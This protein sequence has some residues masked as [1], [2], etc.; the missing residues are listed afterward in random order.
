MTAEMIPLVQNSW[1][2]RVPSPWSSNVACSM[3]R[4]SQLPKR[5]LRSFSRSTCTISLGLRIRPNLAVY[6]VPAAL[7]GPVTSVIRVSPSIHSCARSR[8]V[9][10]SKTCSPWRPHLD[11]EAMVTHARSLVRSVSRAGR[12]NNDSEARAASHHGSQHVELGSWRGRVE[13]VLDQPAGR[14]ET[15]P[16]PPRADHVEVDVGAVSGD[17]VTKV[18]L[19]SERQDGKVV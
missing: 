9:H 10:R 13:A 5:V 15:S 12:C 11:N 16:R 1:V 18:L 17:D 14:H 2:D 8:S 6:W 3:P 4:R 19:M 7:T